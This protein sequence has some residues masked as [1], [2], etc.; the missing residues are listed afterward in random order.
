MA[1]PHTRHVVAVLLAA[2]LAAT[3]CREAATA[4]STT[5]Q[6]EDTQ[7]QEQLRESADIA[8]DDRGKTYDFT[9][10]DRFTVFLDDTGH[11]LKNLSIDPQGVIGYISNGSVRGP[12]NYPMMFEAVQPGEV[13]V[14]NDDF[15]VL[16][17]VRVQ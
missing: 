14:R 17:V 16:I 5:Q 15:R 7:E 6:S 1:S 12:D 10:S 3:G 4:P 11:P 9:V 13:I 2:F 8:L